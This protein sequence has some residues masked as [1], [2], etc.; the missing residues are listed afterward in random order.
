MKVGSKGSE[1]F[2]RRYGGLAVTNL[3]GAELDRDYMWRFTTGCGY[4]F[5]RIAQPCWHGLRASSSFIR[6]LL[7]ASTVAASAVAWAFSNLSRN[8]LLGVGGQLGTDNHEGI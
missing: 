1:M 3:A 4:G 8:E 6:T 2:E 7:L 5:A